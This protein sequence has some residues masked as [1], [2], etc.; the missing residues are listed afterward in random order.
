M[1]NEPK[2]VE[3]CSC[4]T[5]AATVGVLVLLANACRMKKKSV[6]VFK[7]R[8]H[9]Y[10]LCS[11]E[12]RWQQDNGNPKKKKTGSKMICLYGE[13]LEA[14]RFYSSPFILFRMGYSYLD[15]FEDEMLFVGI[16]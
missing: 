15:A 10:L 2:R 14:Q 1:I 5:L 16:T 12:R 6:L 8:N 7:I 13:L 9:H 4:R 11:G 3:K